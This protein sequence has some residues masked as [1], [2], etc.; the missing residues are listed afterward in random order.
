MESA[1]L[2]LSLAPKDVV[3]IVLGCL[4]VVAGVG[5]LYRVDTKIE[6][7]RQTVAELSKILVQE[8]FDRGASIADKYVIGDYDGF[9]HE[10]RALVQ[11]LLNP[12]SRLA[13]LQKHFMKQL[14]NALADPERREK[15][16]KMVEDAK[17]LLPVAAE[18]A[19]KIMTK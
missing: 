12:E 10:L 11:D 2:A 18:V 8:G 3:I 19:G 1:L 16:F 17:A 7:R 13:V 4:V 14:A 6:K 5:L 9:V 15:V